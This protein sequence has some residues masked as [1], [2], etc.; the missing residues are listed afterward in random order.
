L[1]LKYGADLNAEAWGCTPLHLAAAH[2]A[3]D[4][5]DELIH[6]GARINARESRFGKTPLFL[7]V[8]RGDRATVVLL[9]RRGASRDIGDRA[10]RTPLVRAKQ[11]EREDLVRVL[12]GVPET[13]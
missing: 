8:D 13:G 9:L 12:E 7:A 2:G 6:A 3:A 5:A 1:L 10:G 11:L 4:E